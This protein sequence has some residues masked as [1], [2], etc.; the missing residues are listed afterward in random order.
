MSKRRLFGALI[1]GLAGTLLLAAC[2]DDG[3]HGGHQS[4]SGD[5]SADFNDAD[6]TFAQA[7]IPHHEQAVEMAKL[8]PTRASSA[9][10]KDL[11]AR[12]EAAQGPEIEQMRELLERYGADEMVADHG[13]EHSMGGMADASSMDK[14]AQASGPAFDDLFVQLMIEHHEGAVDMAE[15]ELRDGQDP[16][17]MQL[18][19]AIIDAQT[20]EI[21]EM[22]A[23]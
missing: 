20:A 7:M 13:G 18:A 16:A 5:Q 19:Q 12:I 3:G 4:G 8:A 14:L 9:Q 2:G 22:Q 23:L 6:I 1:F 21:A 17:A 15:T 11:A 10:I